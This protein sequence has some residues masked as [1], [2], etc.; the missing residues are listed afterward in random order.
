MLLHTTL[1]VPLHIIAS[2]QALK[3]PTRRPNVNVLVCER[4]DDVDDF[5]MRCRAMQGVEDM[6]EDAGNMEVPGVE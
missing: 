4:L 5:M 1:V 3:D 6:P 2:M